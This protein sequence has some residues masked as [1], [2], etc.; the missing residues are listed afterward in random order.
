MAATRLAWL[1]ALV[2]AAALPACAS[3]APSAPPPESNRLEAD[4]APTPFSAEQL[5]AACPVGRV[6]TFLIES[7][8]RPPVHQTTRFVSSTFNGAVFVASMST[9][10]GQPVGEP[11]R[12]RATWTDLQ[13]HASH[14]ADST[15]ITEDDVRVPAGRFDCW[16]YTVTSGTDVQRLHFAKG[17][18]GPPVRAVQE[19]DGVVQL[20]MR[21][22]EH[23]VEAQ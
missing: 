3:S 9:P 19:V 13:A 15:V 1:V 23:R 16:V 22:V 4:H 8:S 2:L 18:P 21:L 10:D 6:D 20:D 14:P 7:P 11:V 17:L 12:A 5:R